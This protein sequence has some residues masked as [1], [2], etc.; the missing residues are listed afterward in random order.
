MKASI[1]Y[2]LTGLAMARG[3]G[4]EMGRSAR[5]HG[6]A[7]DCEPGDFDRRFRLRREVSIP[8]EKVLQLHGVPIRPASQKAASESMRRYEPTP[9]WVVFDA[10]RIRRSDGGRSKRGSIPKSGAIREITLPAVGTA[11]QPEVMNP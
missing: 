5:L 10:A 2:A 4:A 9:Y 1:G 6:A 7:V 11:F 8:A 3:S